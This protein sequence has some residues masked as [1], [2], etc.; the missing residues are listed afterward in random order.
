MTENLQKQ[1]NSLIHSIMTKVPLIFIFILIF[2]QYG[3]EKQKL[4]GDIL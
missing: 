3:G 2:N 1:D 4:E